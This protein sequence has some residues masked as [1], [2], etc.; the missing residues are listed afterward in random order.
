MKI[1]H[2]EQDIPLICITAGSFPAGILEAHQK[3]KSR[4]TGETKRD[5]YGISRPDK[6][7]EII[8][9]AAAEERKPGEAEE[10]GLDYCLLKRGTYKVIEIKNFMENI[11]AIGQS[12]EK[13]IA[14]PQIDPSGECVEWYFNDSDVRCMVK[15]VES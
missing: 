1:F 4:L 11:P 13:L 15:L 2:S 7:G 6:D 3:L 5:F 8:Y 14:D 10:L 12:F 9:K